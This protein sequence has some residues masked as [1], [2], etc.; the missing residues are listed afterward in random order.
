MSDQVWVVYYSFEG[1]VAVVAEQLAACFPAALERLCPD[2][3][4]PKNGIGKF[5]KG[6]YSALKKDS[7]VLQ[8]LSADPR[9]FARVVLACPVWA[10]TCPPA[11]K[12]FL[13]Q[14]RLSGAEVW[15]IA[16]SMSG[17][18]EKM[19]ASLKALLPGCTVRGTLSLISPLRDPDKAKG[20]IRAFCEEQGL[21]GG[22][23]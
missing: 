12:T 14:A 17:N 4:P 19:F 18:A 7:V 9:A 5:L 13:D 6:G 8:P 15:L 10:G 3:E 23:A 16:C 22:E 11:M 20:Q 1:N 2:R 21:A